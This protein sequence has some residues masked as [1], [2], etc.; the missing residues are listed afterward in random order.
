M[1]VSSSLVCAFAAA[2][3]D[4]FLSRPALP[5][6]QPVAQGGRFETRLHGDLSAV[7]TE[8]THHPELSEG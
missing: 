8:T 4:L 1:I 3:P 6:G 7:V 5:R 2:A